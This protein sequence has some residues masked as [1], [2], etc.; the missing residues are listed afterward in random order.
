MITVSAYQAEGFSL[1]SKALLSEEC[2]KLK[3]HDNIIPE[4]S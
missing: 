1:A 4:V 3:L 2:K